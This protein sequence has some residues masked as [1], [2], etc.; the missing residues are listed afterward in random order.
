MVV[1]KV[2]DEV[3]LSVIDQDN[4]ILAE[5]RIPTTEPVATLRQCLSYFKEEE[6]A[7]GKLDALGIACSGRLICKDSA[8]YG[9]IL[10]TPKEA[11]AYT[12]LVNY[13]SEGLKIPVG[14]DTD[15][16]AAVLAEAQ[17]GVGMGLTDLVYFTIARNRWGSNCQRKSFARFDSSR[18]GTCAPSA[19]G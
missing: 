11:W 9:Q 13:F 15:V 17:W 5:A 4:Q 10:A 14:F 16:N 12:D 7:L 1:L 18:N 3:C 2:G 8:S 19:L 6:A